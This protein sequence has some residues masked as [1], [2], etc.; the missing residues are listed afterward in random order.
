MNLQVMHELSW[1]PA[2]QEEL[3]SSQTSHSLQGTVQILNPQN[4]LPLFPDIFTN[5]IWN[6]DI[7]IVPFF[8]SHLCISSQ[9]N[10]LKPKE[11][12]KHLHINRLFYANKKICLANCLSKESIC[13]R[14]CFSMY[15]SIPSSLQM[16]KPYLDLTFWKCVFSS[17]GMQLCALLVTDTPK[18]I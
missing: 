7:Y 1:C 11:S 17:I 8:E 14:I 9:C 6:G 2:D 18:S 10:T 15:F 12:C 16:N 5:F 4:I 13:Y 3:I